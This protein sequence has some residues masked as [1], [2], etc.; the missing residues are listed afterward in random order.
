M[1]TCGGVFAMKFDIT[2]NFIHRSS[3]E[4]PYSPEYKLI[5]HITWPSFTIFNFQENVCAET[6]KCVRDC[7]V[8]PH[9]SDKFGRKS[10][11]I[12]R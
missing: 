2:D 1:V 5:L 6:V 8:T 4:I 3:G 7:K 12:F 9:L 10:H 11:L